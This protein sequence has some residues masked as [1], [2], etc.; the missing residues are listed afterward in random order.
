MPSKI[1]GQKALEIN[2]LIP[3]GKEFEATL[4]SPEPDRAARQGR[5][6]QLSNGF[7]VTRDHNLLARFHG[8]DEFGQAILS[9]GYR[10]FHEYIL[11][12]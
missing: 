6:G 12:I 5:R 2:R 3:A 8:P 10:N 9:L 4:H 7:P 11:A 1:T